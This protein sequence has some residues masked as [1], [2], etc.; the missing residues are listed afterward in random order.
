MWE[1]HGLGEPC[2]APSK[3]G[4]S[5]SMS[6]PVAQP[7]LNLEGLLRGVREIWFFSLP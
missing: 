5:L 4:S 6:V 2:P 7:Y 3:A 1:A